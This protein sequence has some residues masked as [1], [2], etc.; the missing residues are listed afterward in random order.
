M[1]NLLGN[2]DKSISGRFI[3]CYSLANDI[4][5]KGTS[6]ILAQ[7]SRV[8]N[9]SSKAYTKDDLLA[10]EEAGKWVQIKVINKKKRDIP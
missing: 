2:E 6:T 10:K 7:G 8:I 9:A 1:I 3:I 5:A 4:G